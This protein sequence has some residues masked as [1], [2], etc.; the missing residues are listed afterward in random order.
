M[1]EMSVEDYLAGVE[2]EEDFLQWCGRCRPTALPRSVWVSPG[3]QAFHLAEDCSALIS[4]QDRAARSGGSTPTKPA[5]V[6][7]GEARR[8]MLF[9]C[10][11]CWPELRG[12][13]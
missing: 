1:S 2:C 8:K 7:T 9:P 6:D 4:G 11:V 10:L 5:Q 3:G 12:R 13:V